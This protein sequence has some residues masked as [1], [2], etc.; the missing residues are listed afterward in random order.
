MTGRRATAYKVGIEEDLDLNK[1]CSY[2]EAQ[3]WV[4]DK[5][6]EMRLC[7][8]SKT[9]SGA[10]TCT[11]DTVLPETVKRT[12]KKLLCCRSGDWWLQQ[13]K[14]NPKESLVCWPLHFTCQLAVGCRNLTSGKMCAK[15][16]LGALRMYERKLPA[17]DWLEVGGA[18]CES[19]ACQTALPEP[20]FVRTR[21]RYP[22]DSRDY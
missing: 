13:D 15:A 5:R 21:G 3:A 8:I 18:V 10:T 14:K 17:S 6:T 1:P 22:E 19:R 12:G 11:R 16:M 9:L 2:S 20:H 7:R 4:R